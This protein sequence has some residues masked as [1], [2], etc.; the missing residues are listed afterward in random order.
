M[1]KLK[2]ETGKKFGSLIVLSFA[3]SAP[4]RWVCMCCC[5]HMLIVTG[6]DLRA[7]RYKS[8]GCLSP[9]FTSDR[10]LKHGLSRSRTYRI[11]HGMKQ[12]CSG[13]AKGK[14]RRLYYDKGI[15]VCEDWM[16]FEKFYKDMGAAPDGM[17]IDRIDGNK[18]YEPSNC[19]WA[20]KKSQANNMSSNHVIEFNGKSMTLSAWAS[21]RGIK[22]N[23]LLYR[24]RRGWDVGRALST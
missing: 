9:K 10:T 1:T 11:W 24:L 18:N 12:R 6:T 21:E 13:V 8:C 4:A 5:G 22:P 2:D 20:T 16:D 15:R 23:T 19:R 17:S 3:G 14:S 7:G